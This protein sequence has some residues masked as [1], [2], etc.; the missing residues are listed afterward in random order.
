MLSNDK[1]WDLLLEKRN[2]L[3][4][5]C[6]QVRGSNTYLFMSKM[7]I[8]LPTGLITQFPSGVNRRF[9]FRYTVPSKL[10]NWNEI[11]KICI[12]LRYFGAQEIQILT[13]YANFILSIFV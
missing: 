13:L 2:Q 9:P 1:V 11:Y 6:L 8:R 4:V 7:V 3:E 10:L 5:S 12:T